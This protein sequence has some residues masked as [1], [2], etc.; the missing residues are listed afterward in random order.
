MRSGSDS[1]HSQYRAS[2]EKTRTSCVRIC[3]STSVPGSSRVSV[4][5]L[6]DLDVRILAIEDVLVHKLIAGM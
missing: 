4:E 6:D 2:A 1:A 5:R 3:V